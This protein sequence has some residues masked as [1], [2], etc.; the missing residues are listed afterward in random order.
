MAKMQRAQRTT[1][2]KE[3]VEQNSSELRR[4]AMGENVSH[5]LKRWCP[6][7]GNFTRSEE[8][9]YPLLSKAYLESIMTTKAIADRLWLELQHLHTF[10]CSF[11]MVGDRVKTT[12]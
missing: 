8:G 4:K 9:H 2:E 3:A 12:R 5:E 11:V 10:R 6:F 7:S 1:V